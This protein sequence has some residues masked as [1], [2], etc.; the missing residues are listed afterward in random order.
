MFTGIISN[1][2]VVTAIDR[3]GDTRITIACGYAPETIAIGASIACS[4]VC[5]T[6]VQTGRGDVGRGW[7]AV[8]ASSETLNRTTLGRWRPGT[9]VNLERPL[10][11]GDELGGHMVSGHVDGIATIVSIVQEGASRRFRFEVPPDIERFMAA[12]GSVALDGISFTVN[13]VESLTFGVNVI[14]HTLAVTTWQHAEPGQ[15]VNVEVD[16]LARYVA[17]LREFAP[18]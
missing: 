9:R 2:G 15:P 7:F 12:K 4:G 16:M 10:K 5:L 14:P 17:R 6:A 8:E 18:T 13:E 1:I 3:R 11:L